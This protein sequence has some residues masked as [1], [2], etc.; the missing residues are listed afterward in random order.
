MLP[1]NSEHKINTVSQR[2]FIILHVLE[3][4][5]ISGNWNNRT[6]HFEMLNGSRQQM[7]FL[8][9]YLGIITPNLMMQAFF[10]V[11][12]LQNLGFGNCHF[13]RPTQGVVFRGTGSETG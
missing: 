10:A 7:K 13:S 8:I 12:F 1:P 6:L 11:S 9:G 4:I 5:F 3:I 2:A